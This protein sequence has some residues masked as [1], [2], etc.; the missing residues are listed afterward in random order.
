MKTQNP[1]DEG[2]HKVED[3]ILE[4]KQRKTDKWTHILNFELPGTLGKGEN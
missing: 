1:G 2:R 4:S 3:T